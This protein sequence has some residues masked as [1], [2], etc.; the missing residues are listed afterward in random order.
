MYVTKDVPHDHVNKQ[1]CWD[2]DMA[3]GS[4]TFA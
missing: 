3:S 4:K 2:T 1:G